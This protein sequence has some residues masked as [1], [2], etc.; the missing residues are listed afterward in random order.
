MT[1]RITP[2]Q[3]QAVVANRIQM[4][5][6]HSPERLESATYVIFVVSQSPSPELGLDYTFLA[7]E[8]YSSHA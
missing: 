1:V 4:S 6:Y 7:D 2:I 8:R 3:S 5:F